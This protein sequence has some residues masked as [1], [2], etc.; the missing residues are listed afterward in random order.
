MA[1]LILSYSRTGNNR[2]LAQTVARRTGAVIEEVQPMGW[3]PLP[4]VIWQM[5]TGRL[6]RVR[7]LRHE[8]AA[9]DRLLVMAPVWDRH[10]A[11]PMI[12]ALRKV[13]AEVRRYDFVSLCGY[14]RDR[15]DETIREELVEVVGHPPDAQMELHVGDLLPEAFRNDPRKVSARQLTMAD[16]DV[17]SAQID[18]IVGWYNPA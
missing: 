1:L 8:I 13:K 16:L 4:R 15:Q 3:Y 14:V 18:R 9:Y 6:P 11:F 2:L 10:V 7:T 12:A 17:F 5:A